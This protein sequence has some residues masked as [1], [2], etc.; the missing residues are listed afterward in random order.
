M[1]PD[2]NDQ[3]APLAIAALSAGL[4][5]CIVYVRSS[6]KKA[7]LQKEREI[8]DTAMEAEAYARKLRIIR[9]KDDRQRELDRIW[10]IFKP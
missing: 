7:A 8:V 9:E 6:R 5:V 3:I 10:E 2:E 1:I 4:V